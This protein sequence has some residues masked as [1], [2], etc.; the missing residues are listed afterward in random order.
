MEVKFEV[1]LE[2]KHIF[3]FLIRHTYF[4]FSGYCGLL[5]SL[6][7]YAATIY[8]WNRMPVG[9]SI[10]LLLAGMMFTVIQPLALFIKANKEASQKGSNK[11]INYL[12][13]RE[14]LLLTQNGDTALYRW[15]Q[16]TKI[17]STSL[18]VV[19][20]VDNRRTFI[21]SKEAIGD[22]YEMLKQ[23]VNANAVASYIKI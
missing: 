18:A 22:K 15:Q 11:P 2:R 20:Y 17:T 1:E 3:S 21:L 5:I 7:A 12:I 14:G 4:A 10:M 9:N 16:V 23:I 13:N 8:T 19:I 6:C